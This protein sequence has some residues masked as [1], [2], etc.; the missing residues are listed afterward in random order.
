MET[1]HC[2]PLLLEELQLQ[3]FAKLSFK[4]L[5]RVYES[6]AVSE[7][8]LQEVM[9]LRLM[10]LYPEYLSIS[11]SS[12]SLDWRLVTELHAIKLEAL[13][14]SEVLMGFYAIC[15]EAYDDKYLLRAKL[16][17]SCSRDAARYQLTITVFLS[18]DAPCNSNWLTVLL[19]DNL[20]LLP[21]T[22][23]TTFIVWPMPF[24]DESSPPKELPLDNEKITR[25]SLM[26]RL[27]LGDKKPD[28]TEE[29][30]ALAKN[31]NNWYYCKLLKF[32]LCYLVSSGFTEL[33]ASVTEMLR[34]T[35]NGRRWLRETSRL[36]LLESFRPE[37]SEIEDYDRDYN[38]RLR[39]DRRVLSHLLE[40][41][42]EDLEYLEGQV[43]NFCSE[44]GKV[45][46]TPR[47]SYYESIAKVWRTELLEAT[48][49][50]ALD[51]RM[52]E[53]MDF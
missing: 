14:S 35:D 39:S 3:I 44:L 8:H 31:H 10:E 16:N 1:F 2:F 9:R 42:R 18:H 38:R 21:G 51:R 26:A 46:G 11:S 22:L 25:F 45:L 4:D 34:Q 17:R 7:K 30:Q 36:I 5:L 29:L 33:V 47:F 49:G 43:K 28:V 48:E 6:G 41:H 23:T 32:V 24:L 13:Q 15:N 52:L 40:G 53:E 50:K 27:G 19:V 12:S 37:H 20:Q